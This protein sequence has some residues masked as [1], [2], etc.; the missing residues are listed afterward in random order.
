MNAGPYGDF[1]PE[2]FLNRKLVMQFSGYR[3]KE[4]RSKPI[5]ITIGDNP[6]EP[7]FYAP[8]ESSHLDEGES[9]SRA[10]LRVM[11]NSG[12]GGRGRGLE[13]VFNFFNERFGL[14]PENIR[15]GRTTFFPLVEPDWVG[16]D[17]NT[18]GAYG[19]DDIGCVLPLLYGFVRVK[20]PNYTAILQ[21]HTGEETG[22][23][24]NPSAGEHH[25]VETFLPAL[26]YL[27]DEELGDHYTG[28]VHNGVSLWSDVMEVRHAFDEEAHD[29]YDSAFFHGGIIVERSAGDED[30]CGSSEPLTESL[31][32]F[33]NLLTAKQIPWQLCTMGHPDG[34][35]ESGDGEVHHPLMSRYG[36]NI[37]AG[38]IS[39]HRTEE[40]GSVPDMFYLSE[41]ARAFYGMRHHKDHFPKAPDYQVSVTRTW[42]PKRDFVGG[43]R[44]FRN[45]RK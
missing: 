7:N 37:G 1:I 10:Q 31:E 34:K 5:R 40:L 8:R 17:R 19:I 42:F 18:V 23:A 15:R 24:T 28:L 27:R 44:R 16:L 12:Y 43:K 6:G 25:L 2:A 3:K 41:L 30:L 35:T 45:R 32:G 38:I 20:K 11:I 36:I 29:P 26:S 21:L 33:S 22:D 39:A 14:T 13:R 9:I 4:G